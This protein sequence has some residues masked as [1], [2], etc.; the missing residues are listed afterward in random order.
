MLKPPIMIIG[1]TRSGNTALAE[2]LSTLPSLCYLNEPLY[3]WRVGCAYRWNDRATAKDA[4]PWVIKHIQREL[5]R[6]QR[7]RGDCRI[8]DKTPPNILRVSF[9]HAVLPEAKLICI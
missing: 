4:R 6:F 2:A 3:L 1:P 9:V 8:V 5:E 7:S